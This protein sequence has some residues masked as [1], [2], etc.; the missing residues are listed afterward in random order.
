MAT[1]WDGVAR[2]ET[3]EN[4]QRGLLVD[5]GLLDMGAAWRDALEGTFG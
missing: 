3:V 5:L 2:P 1:G 4:K